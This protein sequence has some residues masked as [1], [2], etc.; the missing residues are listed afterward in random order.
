VSADEL[1]RAG[2]TRIAGGVQLGAEETAE[3]IDAM[4]GGEASPLLVAA[5]LTGMRVAGESS[6]QIVGAARAMRRHSHKVE[7]ARSPLVDTCGT[8]GD[9]KSTFSIST[10]AALVAAGAGAAVAKHGN[11]AASGKFGGADTL[12][13]LGV[14][15][16]LPGDAAG[17]CLDKV[18]MAFLFARALHPAMRHVGKIRSELGIRTIFNLLGPLTNPAGV[19]RQ[20][21]GVASREALDLVAG[22]LLELGSEHA[23]VVHSHDGLDEIS[24][25]AGN[26][27]VEVRD[28]C[29]THWTLSPQDLG[30]SRVDAGDLHA[31]TLA[32]SVAAVR[33][34]LAGEA[35]PQ[36]EIVAAN[37]GAALYVAGVAASLR[38]GV[39]AAKQ[40]MTSG[41]AAGVLT[42]LVEVSQAEAALLRGV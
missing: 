18:G 42:R 1:L 3:C 31:E 19:R 9:G 21:V 37:A 2:L 32:D 20:V 15:I 39:E 7:T 8:G 13:A 17:R 25:A 12:E 10:A 30:L 22:A 35:G 14:A 16:E 33:G 40:S 4:M 29:L 5:L 28:G 23:L 36:A 6:E 24:L 38:S 26:D 11:R 41:A 34:V 27:I